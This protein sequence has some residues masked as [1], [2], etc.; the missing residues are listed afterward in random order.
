M[1]K[2]F[3]KLR[4][5][6]EIQ[7]FKPKR[8]NSIQ[9]YKPLFK[10]LGLHS[11]YNSSYT[12][13][14][15]IL[16]S[17]KSELQTDIIILKKFID[18]GYFEKYFSFDFNSISNFHSYLQDKLNR[19]TPSP[20][21]KSFTFR[22]DSDTT[23]KSE[24]SKIIGY[25]KKWIFT[26]G[27]NNYKHWNKLSNAVN[28]SLSVLQKFISLGFNGANYTNDQVTKNSI[29]K[30]IKN[31]LNKDCHVDDLVVISF[32][33]HGYT[34][35]V[36]KQPRGFIVPGDAQK[37]PELHE[38]I[39]IQELVSWLSYISSKHILLL[40]DCCF[41]GFST[42]RSIS[43]RATV[44][45]KQP[46]RIAINA[47]THRQK[48]LDGGWGNHSVFTGALLTSECLKDK[49]STITELYNEIAS[50]VSSIAE[51]TPTMGRLPGDMGG[52]IYIGL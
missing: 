46:C 10:E 40:F 37:P 4:K 47:G 14:N 29:E 50:K 30:I 19:K 35:K 8:V 42:L 5:L 39:C 28:D 49:E 22:S 43:R 31:D 12:N 51:Q 2:K 36:S 6:D 16:N 24:L 15:E 13:L 20:R 3:L 23:V 7:S 26:F 34:T 1:N 27:I 41:S 17:D 44:M 48:V 11:L 21:N 9:R 33:G 25:R 45:I 32:H 38:I 52:E 18:K